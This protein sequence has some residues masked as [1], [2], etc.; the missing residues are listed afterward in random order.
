M[1]ANLKVSLLLVCIIVAAMSGAAFRSSFSPLTTESRVDKLNIPSQHFASKNRSI[2]LM[3]S[4]SKHN[5]VSDLHLYAL[6]CVLC[7]VFRI[8]A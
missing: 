5:E 4:D 2:E 1:K 7:F 8:I 3:F 6:I